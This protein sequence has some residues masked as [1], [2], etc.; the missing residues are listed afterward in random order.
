MDSGR[1]FR[2]RVPFLGLRVL[3]VAGVALG[4]GLIALMAYSMAGLWQ[5]STA[6]DYYVK[7]DLAPPPDAV[8]VRRDSLWTLIKL[9]QWEQ[10]GVA[11]G[12]WTA[13]N[14]QDAA[15]ALSFLEDGY[16][17]ETEA[18]VRRLSE[19]VA[20]SGEVTVTESREP[21]MINADEAAM[22]FTVGD[23]PDTERVLM[24]FVRVGEGWKIRGLADGG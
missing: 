1:L 15:R 9:R 23:P 3:A 18:T 14:E 10:R 16:G 22:Y 2:L 8:S 11:D 5:Q 17:A 21:Y 19:R 13:L 7:N 12:Y 6:R 20:R 24:T 4:V